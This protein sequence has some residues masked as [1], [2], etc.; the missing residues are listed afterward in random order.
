MPPP[1]TLWQLFS[2]ELLGLIIR[3]LDEL[4]SDEYLINCI[5]F[6]RRNASLS[7]IC[8]RSL[9]FAPAKTGIFEGAKHL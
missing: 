4:R 5:F 2:P 1:G 8:D 7:R 6:K 9:I 3:G